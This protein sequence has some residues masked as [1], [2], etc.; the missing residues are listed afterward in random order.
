M[1]H[2]SSTRIQLPFMSSHGDEIQAACSE[3]ATIYN[4]FVRYYRNVPMSREEIKVL[5]SIQFVADILGYSDA[6]VAKVLVDLGLRAPRLAFPAAFLEYVDGALKRG[7][8][9]IGAPGEGLKA[10][11]AHWDLI[12]EDKADAFRSLGSLLDEMRVV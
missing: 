9:E 5:S 10:L 8:W 11:R 7:G 2:Y 1:S 4:R 3:R 12:G 6:H